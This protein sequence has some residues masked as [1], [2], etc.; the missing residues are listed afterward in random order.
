MKAAE[1][2]YDPD[3]DKYENVVECY[4]DLSENFGKKEL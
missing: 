4:D 3:S 1:I 2:E